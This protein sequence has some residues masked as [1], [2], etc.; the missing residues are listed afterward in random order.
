MSS[1]VFLR[2]YRRK[3]PIGFA[4]SASTELFERAFLKLTNRLSKD[5][6]VYINRS[7][8]P[9]YGDKI[10]STSWEGPDT[11][12][13]KEG[14]IG[15]DTPVTEAIEYDTPKERFVYEVP[16]ITVYDPTGMSITS[17]GRILLESIGPPSLLQRGSRRELAIAKSLSRNKLDRY[18]YQL[19]TSRCM[20][21]KRPIDQLEIACPLQPQ[22][23]NYY[24]WTVESLLR[25]DLVERYS[26]VTSQRPTL[27]LP[28]NPP[29]WLL[30]TL[31]HLGYE[32][33]WQ[34]CTRPVFVKRLVLPSYPEPSKTG[35]QCL[36]NNALDRVETSFSGSDRVYV[37]RSKATERRVI[38]EGQLDN[39]LSSYGF[40]CY[41]LE[42]LNYAEQVQLFADANIVLGPHGAG[43]CNIIYSQD[44]TL[45]EMFG[46]EQKTTFYRLCKLL[47]FEYDSVKG[48]PAGS[49]IK[50]DI[51]EIE[52]QFGNY[53]DT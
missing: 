34:I 19:T 10:E 9:D 37:S 4:S 29:S 51:D 46:E 47:G 22:Y 11:L 24:H 44:V 25:L 26:E 2:H 36:R 43:L 18:L 49:D 6:D 53:F 27:L 32:D 20:P 1:T 15:N 52:H 3:G 40:E 8:L 13:F 33:Q 41:E 39:L 31:S 45:L 21:P 28:P 35:C 12:P 7:E 38:N 23:T 30:D 42:N 50:I 14:P 16:D 5:S 48:I 17:D